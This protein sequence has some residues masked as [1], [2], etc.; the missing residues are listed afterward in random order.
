[1]YKTADAVVRLEALGRAGLTVSVCC[2][3]CGSA[4]LRWTVLAMSRSG[5]EFD[6][7]FA[8]ADFPHAVEIAELEAVKR[9]WLP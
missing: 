3:P 2:G 9:G 8:A 6:R 1:M 7:P 5:Q 4:P